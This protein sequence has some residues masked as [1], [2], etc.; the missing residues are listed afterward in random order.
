MNI[1]STQVDKESTTVHCYFSLTRLVSQSAGARL[2]FSFNAILV[3]YKDDFF[4]GASFGNIFHD[5]LSTQIIVK[6]V[7]KWSE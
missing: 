6:N 5:K 2:F 4:G 7:W 3:I 1:S